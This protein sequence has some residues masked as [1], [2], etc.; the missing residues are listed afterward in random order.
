MDY[1][2]LITYVLFA[3]FHTVTTWWFFVCLI[4]TFV[5][6]YSPFSATYVGATTVANAIY[7]GCPFT[8]IEN[9]IASTVG[10]PPKLVGE[11]YVF[12]GDLGGLV[13]V[14]LLIAGIGFLYNA[15][16][17]WHD[18]ETPIRVQNIWMKPSKK[19]IA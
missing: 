16:Q 9:A 19:S 6:K 17:V 15:Y 11:I 1:L 5:V 14:V 4:R 12:F 13:R 3:A 10:V 2:L 7:G 18:A 8:E